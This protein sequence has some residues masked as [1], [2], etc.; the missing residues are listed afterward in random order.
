MGRH[1]RKLQVAGLRALSLAILA[2]FIACAEKDD[3][4]DDGGRDG[5]GDGGDDAGGPRVNYIVKTL[6]GESCLPRPLAG[7]NGSVP[8]QVI[9][10]KPPSGATCSC[11]VSPGRSGEVAAGLRDAVEEEL[12]VGEYC[13]GGTNI[14]CSS[15]C[16]CEIQQLSGAE[17][18]ACLNSLADPG[19]IH[20]FCYVAPNEGAGNPELVAACPVTEPQIIRFLGEN[21]PSPGAV[22]FIGCSGSSSPVDAGAP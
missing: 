18:D 19:G 20:G 11:D 14:A 17:L 16:L 3:G 4:R 12:V 8:C 2:S 13:D 21:V 1:G 5:G 6:S 15:F 22:V 10:A 9:E 7:E